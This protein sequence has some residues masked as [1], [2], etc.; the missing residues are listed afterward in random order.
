MVETDIDS[1]VETAPALG[2]ARVLCVDDDPMVLSAIRR[3]L[4]REPYSI[5][6]TDDPRVALQWVEEGKADVLLTDLWMPGMTGTELLKQA[7]GK[8]PEL[9][10]AILTAHPDTS[11]LL[12]R[13]DGDVRKLITKPWNEPDLKRAIRELISGRVAPERPSATLPGMGAWGDAV[14]GAALARLA[15]A[16]ASGNREALDTLRAE[17]KDRLGSALGAK[18]ESPVRDASKLSGDLLRGALEGLAGHDQEAALQLSLL[19]AWTACFV[20]EAMERATGLAKLESSQRQ[21]AESSLSAVEKR[22]EL[23]LGSVKD[24]A[25]CLVD[26]KGVIASWNKGAEG[27]YGYG[28]EEIVGQP[29]RRFYP[30]GETVPDPKEALKQASESG[31][32]E[33]EGWKVRKDGQKF[34]AHTVIT[35]I[36]KLQGRLG[37]YLEIT[38][39]VTRLRN[40]LEAL[41]AERDFIGA[42]LDTVDALV[43]VF[44]ADGRIVRWNRACEQA[45]GYPLGEVEGRFFWEVLV[46]PEEKAEVAEA[47]RA[48]A[49]AAETTKDE[50]TWIAKSG[51]KRRIAWSST[52]VVASDVTTRHTIITGL[53]VTERKRL[54]EQIAQSQK[55]EAMGRLAGGVSHDFNNLLT[56]IVG[57]GDLLLAR[58]SPDDPNRELLEEMRNA[59]QRGAQ[60]TRQLLTFSR[61]HSTEPVALDL[62]AS[63]GGMEKLLRRVIGDDVELAFAKGE[64][65][66][67]IK[68]DAGQIEQVLMNLV[69]NA[70]DAMPQGGKITVETMNVELDGEY[71]RTHLEVRPGPHVQLSVSDTGTGMDAQTL[72]RVFEP[73]FTTKGEG[74]GT[75]LGLATV[76]GIVK[77]SGGHI[78]LYSELGHGTTFKLF[79]PSLAQGEESS[80]LPP[81]PAPTQAGNET[82]LLVEDSEPVRL[83]ARRIL[84]SA[85]YRVLEAS[86]GE[87]AERIA[88]EH[89]GE[90]HLL[91]T[92]SVMPVMGGSEVARRISARRP[93]VKIVYMSG[94]SDRA[95]ADKGLMEAGSPFL[96]K[97]FSREALLR[98]VRETIDAGRPAAQG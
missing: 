29:R 6:T 79:F 15:K 70:R 83:L 73:F 65:L 26:E 90:I 13:C 75:G 42:V 95:T 54:E 46:A 17:A 97:P 78:A 21:M 35:A 81:P 53:D 36:P 68:A 9:Q 60:L 67:R 98:R 18:G 59:G 5:L 41:R 40:T 58:M 19:S 93:D 16:L 63:L 12:K 85:G 88:R 87:V 94:Y 56:V 1:G 34:W 39:D 48:R 32:F 89:P 61:K 51:L 47:F 8:L 66:G 30:A 20:Q 91:L 55:M 27:I 92:D 4:R 74:K 38:R 10:V 71:A 31:R 14:R 77:Q 96:Q 25:I 45:T 76:H 52:V 23:I 43:A 86:G 84:E 64:N 7:K 37:G 2:Q 80:S 69:V 28:A 50:S 11:A 82:V 72:S 57:Y 3:V 62:N 33:E 22:Y 24:Y 49:A 44:D